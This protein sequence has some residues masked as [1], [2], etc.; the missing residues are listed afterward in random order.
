MVYVQVTAETVWSVYVV[1][2]EV[3]SRQIGVEVTE[4]VCRSPEVPGETQLS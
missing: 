2:V 1:V 3:N 4:I